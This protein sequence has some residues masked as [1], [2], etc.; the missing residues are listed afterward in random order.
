MAIGPVQL[1]VVAFPSDEL[2]AGL[3][4]ELARL[5]SQDAVRLLDLLVVRKHPDGSVER[6]E[7]SDM[8]GTEAEEL[9][10]L[11]GALVGF[12]AG[13]EAAAE[14]GAEA[15]ALAAEQGATPLGDVWYVDDA[16]EPGTS[17]AVALIEHRWAIGLRDG[18]LAAGGSLAADSWV[19]PLD[20]VAIGLAAA[21]DAER[22]LA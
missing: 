5:R 9:G 8:P 14:A 19:H 6:L 22:E 7:V 15:G 1:L 20:L 21:E 16:I 4:A 12:G 17:A 2:H 11:V 10:A 13:G 18:I 3:R